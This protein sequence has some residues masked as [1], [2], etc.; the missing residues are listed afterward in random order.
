MT[1]ENRKLFLSYERSGSR[2]PG[3]CGNTLGLNVRKR[4]LAIKNINDDTRTKHIDPFRAIAEFT[5]VYTTRTVRSIF[6]VLKEN[7][8]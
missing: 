2:I 8:A 3:E 6:G 7:S 5:G 1:P 4:Y